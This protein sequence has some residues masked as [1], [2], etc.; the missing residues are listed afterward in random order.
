M[1]KIVEV[2]LENIAC[3]NNG[4]GGAVSGNTLVPR[5]RISISPI[6]ET[7]Y[8]LPISCWPD[9]HRRG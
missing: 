6:C 9:I 2:A 3:T 8:N 1:T 7:Q 5:F 4:F